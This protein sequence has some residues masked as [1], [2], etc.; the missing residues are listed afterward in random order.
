MLARCDYTLRTIAW[1][2]SED[3]SKGINRPEPLATPVEQAAHDQMLEASASFDEDG[4]FLASILP[5][6]TN[7]PAGGEN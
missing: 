5:H 1:M 2:F 3:G 4:A 6:V 7:P